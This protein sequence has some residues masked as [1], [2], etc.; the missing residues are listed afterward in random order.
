[1]ICPDLER[2]SK[3]SDADTAA[4]SQGETFRR[5]RDRFEADGAEGLY[6]R[7]LSK[8]PARAGGREVLAWATSISRRTSGLGSFKR[9]YNWDT[10]MASIEARPAPAAGGDDQDASSHEW[11][12]GQIWDLAPWTIHQRGLGFFVHHEHVPSA[13]R[14]DLVERACSARSTPTGRHTPDGRRQGRQGQLGRALSSGIELIAAYSPE[15]GGARSACSGRRSACR[16]SCAW[17][18]SPPWKTPTGILKEVFWPATTGASRLRAEASGLGLRGLSPAPS[19][20]SSASRR[21]ATVAGDN[22][23]RYA[24]P[25]RHRHHYVKAKVGTNIPTPG[26]AVFHGPSGPLQGR[27]RDYRNRCKGGRVPLRRDR[28]PACGQVDSSAQPT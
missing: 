6:D 7:R 25:D 22:T 4:M 8:V 21:S 12:A 15:A 14:G 16:R 23:V 5:W 18:A 13:A 17:P 3:A 9:S 26:L 20:T 2:S 11:V 10:Q 27:R 19:P 1:M 24:D 28:P